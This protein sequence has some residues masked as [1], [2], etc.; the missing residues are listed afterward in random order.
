[1]NRWLAEIN[2]FMNLFMIENRVLLKPVCTRP[3]HEIS[4]LNQPWTRKT[5]SNMLPGVPIYAEGPD[6]QEFYDT[7]LWHDTWITRI[8]KSENLGLEFV[9]L[10]LIIFFL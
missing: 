6:F 8:Y 7:I 1:M 2:V 10:S 3:E 4:I 9:D 5:V